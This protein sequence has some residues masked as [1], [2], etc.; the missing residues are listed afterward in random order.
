M[1]R[2]GLNV[3]RLSARLSRLIASDSAGLQDSPIATSEDAVQGAVER[4]ASAQP[5]AT[6]VAAPGP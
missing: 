1:W 2:A 4:Q 5:G 3:E 6:Y